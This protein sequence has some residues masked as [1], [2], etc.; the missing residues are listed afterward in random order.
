MLCFTS[1]YSTC[2][3]INLIQYFNRLIGKCNQDKKPQEVKHKKTIKSFSDID[4][5]IFLIQRYSFAQ[6][7]WT[8]LIF[9]PFTYLAKILKS[10][11]HEK[12]IIIYAEA[13]LLMRNRC[14][15]INL[16]EVFQVVNYYINI[17]LI[18]NV[19]WFFNSLTIYS[20]C[21]ESSLTSSYFD[22]Y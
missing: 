7:K 16:T 1:L 3:C 6:T 21:S 5:L 2:R 20:I 4:H 17:Y 9:D 14:T 22:R 12:F 11:F 10:Y 19:I 8:K 13:I 15:Y 18:S